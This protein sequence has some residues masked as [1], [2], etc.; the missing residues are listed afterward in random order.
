MNKFTINVWIVA[1]SLLLF[2]NLNAQVFD[3]S[4]IGNVNILTDTLDDVPDGS[5][6]L[7]G[8]GETYNLGGDSIVIGKSLVFDSSNPRADVKPHLYCDKNYDM[9][10]GSNITSLIFKNLRITGDFSST[11][12][13]NISNSGTIGEFRAENCDFYSLRGIIR[14]KGGTGTLDKYNMI[15]CTVDSL[16][17]YGVLAI[18][19]DSWMCNDIVIK[20]STI[21][22]TEYFLI[23]RNNSNSVLIENCTF[24]AMPETGKP[25]FRWRESGQDNVL[26]GI[27]LRN[28]IYSHA[29]DVDVTGS[30]A[31]DGYDGLDTTTWTI[32][33]CYATNEYNNVGEDTIQGFPNVMFNGTADDLWTDRANFDY[34]FKD[35]SFAGN[36]YAGDPR[37]ATIID[38]SGNDNAD[39]L[40]DTLF[41]VQAGSTI[42]LG[43]GKT[44]NLGGDSIVI[45]NSFI[46]DSSDS[47]AT[48]K[49]HLYCN[50]NYDIVDSSNIT[51]LI[52][53]NLRITGDFSSTYMF[54]ITKSGTIGEFRVENCD[55]YS[56]RGLIRAKGGT[57]TLDKYNMIN[58][59]VD[60][61]RNYGIMAMDK[62]S[63]M[64]NDIVV[65]NSTIR[66]T[67]YFLISRNNT[68]SVL[69]ENCT[70]DAMPETGRP[71]FR[72]REPG[73]NNILNGIT[74]KNVIYSHAWD[75]DV[76]GSVATDGF[77]GLDSTTWT[78]ENCYATN[79]YNNVGEDTIQ[80]FPNVMFNG[81]ADD[82]WND[83]ANFDYTFK[84]STFAGN[85]NAGDPRW[86][87]A[88]TSTDDL[89]LKDEILLY[90]NP[91]NG[92][93]YVKISEPTTLGIYDMAGNLLIQ[94]KIN[95]SKEAINIS[96]LATGLYIVK[97]MDGLRGAIKLMVK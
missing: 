23:S 5:T 13:F 4:G 80:G 6:I 75:V 37:W 40:K 16:R 93:V 77:D 82:L 69:I 92:E 87:G 47:S 86:H 49:P 61:I 45:G 58:C 94:Q 1:C 17:N 46:F 95:A 97:S 2:G 63:W 56:L 36:G 3:L 73:Q 53:K 44:Y 71:W 35:P 32:E 84:D 65:K 79:E 90:P 41:D 7:L 62:D 60:S 12:L 52:F 8:P 85:G 33:N 76:T 89:T 74:L 59:T 88:T 18:D 24:D 10:D 26:N 31:T 20:N 96:N 70:F 81:T 14:I 54:N 72:W 27:T 9:I 50:K 66:E 28:V 25:W 15:N 67:E 39:I 19:K 57:G 42:L 38:L 51:F 48:E 78:I 83:R 30:V 43:P 64:C 21:R 29:W 91:A 68:N 22:E 55:F 11:Y 34:T